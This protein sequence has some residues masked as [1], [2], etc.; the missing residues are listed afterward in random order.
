MPTAWI[1][2]EVFLTYRGV[3]VYNTYKNGDSNSGPREYWFTL[4]VT[5]NED[6]EFDVRD[7]PTWGW[8]EGIKGAIEA[9]IDQGLLEPPEDAMPT[10]TASAVVAPTLP[11]AAEREVH[12]ISIVVEHYVYADNSHMVQAA[13]SDLMDDLKSVLPSNEFEARCEITVVSP[14]DHIYI[15][16]WLMAQ[17]EPEED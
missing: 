12:K 17:F 10:P 6:L 5:E 13:Y 11:A 4:D 14:E 15:K 9:A 16:D 8:T 3:T 2:P 7:L 1:E